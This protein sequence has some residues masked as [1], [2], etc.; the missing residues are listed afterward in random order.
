MSELEENLI[1]RHRFNTQELVDTYPPKLW[2]Q[3]KKRVYAIASP[4]GASHEGQIVCSRWKIF[5]LPS[6]FARGDRQTEIIEKTGY[7][8][9]LPMA[10][11]NNE[12][13][14][15]PNFAH[16]DLFA[17][18]DGPL[19]AQDE[20]QAAE[21]PALASLREALLAQNISPFTVEAGEPTPILIRGVERRCAIAT[22]PNSEQG[23]PFGLYGNNFAGATP[24]AIELATTAIDPPTITNIIAME[25]PP[26]GYG[27]YSRGE[28]EY[29][30]VTAFTAFSAAKY[31]S[32][33]A[34][35]HEVKI[36]IHTGFWGCGAY[37][38]NRVLMTILQLLAAHFAGVDRLVFHTGSSTSDRDFA[39]A[40]EICDRD[41]LPPNSTI[42]IPELID[43]IHAM[44]FLW[45]VS[46]GN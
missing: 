7:F 28:I 4:P 9:Y 24:E 36:A 15:Y 34:L 38:G 45:G 18:Y 30:L 22:N 3:H 42:E 29:I 46:D 35:N 16:S 1:Y 25:A 21:H 37:G 32:S 13:E 11:M 26:G 27:T 10:A 41:L 43:R 44:G 8:D 33:L 39:T 40:C 23:R 6:S 19:F 12:M 20:M 31:E 17:F 14:W 5:A 2:H